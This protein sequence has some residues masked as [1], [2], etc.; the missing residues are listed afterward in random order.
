MEARRTG[1]SDRLTHTS[2]GLSGTG[3][4]S[5]GLCG[6]LTLPRDWVG[7]DLTFHIVSKESMGLSQFLGFCGTLTVPW[8]LFGLSQ[9]LLIREELTFP[10]DCR[11]LS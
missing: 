1:R 11:G 10:K 7:Y 8:D 9:L 3:E 2:L 6:T 4:S 5:Q